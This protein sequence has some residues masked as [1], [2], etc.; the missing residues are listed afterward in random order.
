MDLLRSLL[1]YLLLLGGSLANLLACNAIQFSG[2]NEPDKSVQESSFEDGSLSGL[3]P[4]DIAQQGDILTAEN[5]RPTEDAESLPGYYITCDPN[6]A[7]ISDESMS[8]VDLSCQLTA[9]SMEDTLIDLADH[10]E[11]WQWTYQNDREDIQVSIRE[12]SRKDGWH[13]DFIFS[14][15]SQDELV[16]VIS[17]TEISIQVKEDGKIKSAKRRMDDNLRLTPTI[18]VDI[19][20]YV[21]S[22]QVSYGSRQ[23]NYQ[24][25]TLSLQSSNNDLSAVEAVEYHIHPTFNQYEYWRS[26]DSSSNFRTPIYSTYAGNWRTLGTKVFLKNG[27]TIE[28]LGS[29]IVWP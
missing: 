3:A 7:G 22:V 4:N 25:F 12:P 24:Q 15:G 5:T 6:L 2:D 14:G 11:D 20:V 26:Q 19:K 8:T 9:E 1:L 16:Q 27:E 29:L 10:F 21:F 23:N 17:A 18:N 28:L 13:V